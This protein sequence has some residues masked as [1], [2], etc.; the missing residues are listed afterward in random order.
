MTVETVVERALSLLG[1]PPVTHDLVGRLSNSSS[2]EI[3]QSARI[4]KGCLLR[5]TIDLGPKSRLSR[6]CVLN[7]DVTVGR[8]TNL[9]PNCDV[10][11]DVDVGNYCA[12]ARRS[13][14]QQTNHEM[15]QPS[16][17]IRLYDEVL[18]S[19]LPP[20]ASGPITVGND[21]WIGTRTTILSGVTI[22]DGAIV[23][24]G[25]VV[26]DDVEPYAVVAGVPAERIRWR[27]PR[28]VRE[29][30][31]SLEWWEWDEETIRAH[32]PFFERKLERAD[33]V[34]SVARVADDADARALE[35]TPSSFRSDDR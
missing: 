9:E 31:L 10:V 26:T 13:T 23:G 35:G 28:E 15:R 2:F 29:K 27:F 20:T 33:D 32:R 16:L 22:G 17:Q 8:G 21:V 18:E 11:G 5:G 25:S 34:P 3:A 19:D 7:G 30:L 24:A 4:S 6:G 12:I 1:Y 14:F